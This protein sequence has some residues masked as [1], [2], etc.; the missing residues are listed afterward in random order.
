MTFVV[1]CLRFKSVVLF[2]SCSGAA[3]VGAALRRTIGDL[4]MVMVA[5]VAG[6]DKV[7]IGTI[8]NEASFVDSVPVLDHGVVSLAFAVGTVAVVAGVDKVSIG[9][10]VDGAS[11]VASVPVLDHGVVF[12]AVAVGTVRLVGFVSTRV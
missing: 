5:V 4:V 8:V 11:F 7:S 6:V 12:L 3:V 1:D 10:T 9:S 2:V